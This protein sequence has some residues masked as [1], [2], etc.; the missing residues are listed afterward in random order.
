MA[1]AH[2]SRLASTLVLLQHAQVFLFVAAVVL[3]A[4]A[5]CSCPAIDVYI[6]KRLRPSS[7]CRVVLS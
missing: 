7:S 3:T 4:A 1:R 6:S 5:S 2:E